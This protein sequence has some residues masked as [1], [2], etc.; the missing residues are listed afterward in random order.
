M[1]GELREELLG[2]LLGQLDAMLDA[3]VEIMLEDEKENWLAA[4]LVRLTLSFGK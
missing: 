1:L 3:L 4:V 2:E